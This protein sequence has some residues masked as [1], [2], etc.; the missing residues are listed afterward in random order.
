[1]NGQL[2]IL[3]LVTVLVGCVQPG[4]AHSRS[5]TPTFQAVVDEASRLNK[6]VE[7]LYGEGKCGEAVLVA[8][9]ALAQSRT[10]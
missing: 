4:D 6:L 3:T 9:R 7:K 10:P 8:Q 1:M 5:S 2:G